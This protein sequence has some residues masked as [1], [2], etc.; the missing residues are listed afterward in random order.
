MLKNYRE[1]PNFFIADFSNS[2]TAWLD[3]YLMSMCKHNIIANSTFSW[4]GAWLN[5]NLSKEVVAP[6]RWINT[7]AMLDICPDSWIRL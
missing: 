1:R 2:E 6:K 4:W 7:K 3:M 5:K